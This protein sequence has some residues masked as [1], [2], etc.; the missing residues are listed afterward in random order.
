MKKNII[1][2]IFLGGSI[3]NAS[4]DIGGIKFNKKPLSNTFMAISN[5]GQVPDSKVLRD[6]VGVK[7]MAFGKDNEIN[8]KKTNEALLHLSEDKTLIEIDPKLTI[9]ELS[10]NPYDISVNCSNY[11][12]GD[13]FTLD[14]KS[15][16]V[17]DNDTLVDE[18][19]NGTNMDTL[20]TSKVT[21][22][23][24]LF[25]RKEIHG[26]IKNW[27]TSH[28]TDFEFFMDQ[29]KGDL[30]QD[31]S[32]FDMHSVTNLNGFFAY[33]DHNYDIS[34]WNVSNVENFRALAYDNDEFDSD[35]SN[36]DTSNGTNMDYLMYSA[37]G[38]NQDLSNWNTSKVTAHNSFNNGASAWTSDH[39]PKF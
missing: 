4:W 29:A 16:L 3:L 17:V 7:I 33:I 34:K 8:M 27:D 22:M 30:D 25:Y 18:V 38:F 14:G 2:M 12:V 26:K 36:W 10:D 11:S 15:Y 24:K 21:S 39:L 28:V 32:H 35:I 1:L 9:K 13:N 6:G 37:S 5:G 20:C 23:N 19:S 31:L